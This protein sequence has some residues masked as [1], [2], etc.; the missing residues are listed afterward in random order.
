MSDAA[1][2]EE[3]EGYEETAFT[4]ERIPRQA[5][6]PPKGK[7]GKLGDAF[8]MARLPWGH[9]IGVNPSEFEY[10]YSESWYMPYEYMGE[11]DFHDYNMI[12]EMRWSQFVD[13]DVGLIYRFFRFWFVFWTHGLSFIGLGGGKGGGGGVY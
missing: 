11:K 8:D 6:P 2:P 13:E 12:N 3:Q 1:H 7:L 4:A 10:E 9:Y 5:P